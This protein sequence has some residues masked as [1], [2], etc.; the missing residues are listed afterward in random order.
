M[1]LQ[2]RNL[3]DGEITSNDRIFAALSYLFVPVVSIIVLILD[4]TKARSFP[5]YH[6]IQ[7]LG[8]MAAVMIY[9][10][11]AMVI[12]FCGSIV[13]LGI[14]SVILWILFFLP[15]IPMIYYTYKAGQGETFTIPSVT[16]IMQQQGWLPQSSNELMK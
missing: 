3:M 13:T 16:R 9:E 5:R 2:P 10:F 4:D 8:F 7:S 6:A 12:F 14:G 1:T 11:L 15:I